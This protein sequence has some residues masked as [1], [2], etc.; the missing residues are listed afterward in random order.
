VYQRFVRQRLAAALADTPVVLLVGPRRAGKTGTVALNTASA[1]KIR[2]GSP[3]SI[4][5]T[6]RDDG[7]RRACLPAMTSI[8]HTKKISPRSHDSHPTS[9][10]DPDTGL[11][12]AG[13]AS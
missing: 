7:L 1:A 13:G 11:P 8:A 5:I 12:A 9:T 10:A 2:L 4:S 6:R 3:M